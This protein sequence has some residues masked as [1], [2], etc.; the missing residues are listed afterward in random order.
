L[1]KIKIKS[2]TEKEKKIIFIVATPQ[3]SLT[4]PQATSIK[5]Q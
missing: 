4:T 1:K 2:V 3:S 5:E